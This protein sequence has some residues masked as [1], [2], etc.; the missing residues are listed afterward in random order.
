M[1]HRGFSAATSIEVCACAGALAGWIAGQSHEHHLGR[2]VGSFRPY[3]AGEFGWGTFPGFR[4]AASGAIF[5]ASLRDEGLDTTAYAWT[6][7]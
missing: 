4:Y 6:F 2:D 3:R 1:I 5:S 7:N